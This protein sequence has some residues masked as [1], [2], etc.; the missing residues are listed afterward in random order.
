M[1]TLNIVWRKTAMKQ[2]RAST[3]WYEKK[4]G[5]VAASKFLRDTHHTV[6]L[7]SSYPQMGR[8]DE[9][10]STSKTTYYSFLSHPKYRIVYRFTETTLYIVALRATAMKY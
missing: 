1:G 3:A 7:L 6:N 9:K 5:I 2:L 10:R 4:L 8:I